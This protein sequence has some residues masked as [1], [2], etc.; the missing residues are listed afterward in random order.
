[1]PK[2]SR[3]ARAK[4]AWRQ[5]TIDQC[6]HPGR[7]RETL[8]TP[9]PLRGR[10]LALLNR[11][12]IAI[13]RYCAY[14]RRTSA[15]RDQ[16]P[17]GFTRLSDEIEAIL[18]RRENREVRPMSV[19]PW[20]RQ[21]LEKTLARI[22]HFQHP[23]ATTRWCVV[24][25]RFGTDPMRVTRQSS[26]QKADCRE[27]ELNLSPCGDGQSDAHQAKWIPQQSDRSGDG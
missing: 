20:N 25:L 23:A 1:M 17:I 14:R 7:G 5:R 13:L 4:R 22:R 21:R 15:I 9:L 27:G 11:A 26:V 2:L 10:V 8:L 18:A 6:L 12:T 3:S 16:K 24:S 19:R